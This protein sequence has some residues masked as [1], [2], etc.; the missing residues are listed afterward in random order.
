[1]SLFPVKNRLESERSPRRVVRISAG[2]GKYSFL[3]KAQHSLQVQAPE[4]A[5]C[6]DRKCGKG[7]SLFIFKQKGDG[8]LTVEAAMA[9]SAFLF[10]VLGML[11]F[12]FVIRTEIQIQSVLEQTGNQL[13]CVPETA[14]IPAAIDVFQGKLEENAV[15]A[16]YIVGERWG[17]SLSRSTVMGHEPIIDLVA[18]YRMKLPFLPEGASIDVVQRSRKRAF[19]ASAYWSSPEAKYVYVT[20]GGEVYHEDLYCTYIR[21]K[22]EMVALSEVSQRRNGN[23]SIYYAC[24][25]CCDGEVDIDVWITKWGEAY[26]QSEHCRGIW[27]DVERI[28]LKEAWGRRGCSKCS[29]PIEESEDRKGDN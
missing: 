9:M 15:D 10:A 11:N 29:E 1:M 7:T 13:A 8:S 17:I 3:S 20:R 24:A 25:F 2:T 28:P 14:S 4:M 16:S 27:H 23:G 21:P 12:F 26:H 6:P 22:T 5:N 18:K 19:G